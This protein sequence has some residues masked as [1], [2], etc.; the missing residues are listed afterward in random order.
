MVFLLTF[1][2]YGTVLLIAF[3]YLAAFFAALLAAFLAFL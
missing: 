3:N 1:L 2:F